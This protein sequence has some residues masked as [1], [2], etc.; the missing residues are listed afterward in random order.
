ML[1]SISSSKLFGVVSEVI[2]GLGLVA[3]QAHKKGKTRIF[4]VKNYFYFRA[5]TQLGLLGRRWVNHIS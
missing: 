1:L 3:Q 2:S 4:V 5:A